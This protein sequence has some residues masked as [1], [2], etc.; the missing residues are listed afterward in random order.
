MDTLKQI[1]EQIKSKNIILYM[2]G[3][4][5]IPQCGFSATTVNILM[6]CGKKFA[7]VDILANPNIRAELPKYA[8]WLTFS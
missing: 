7:Y 8:N 1:E 4:P 6:H 2:K 5:Q 3:S